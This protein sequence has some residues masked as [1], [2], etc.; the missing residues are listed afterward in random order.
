MVSNTA[1]GNSILGFIPELKAPGDVT[2]T[3]TSNVANLNGAHGMEIKINEGAVVG[4]NVNVFVE[5][6]VVKSNG[7]DGIRLFVDSGS[8]SYDIDFGG[9]TLGSL[10]NNSFTNNGNAAGEFDLHDVSPLIGA[11]TI[12]AQSNF[13]NDPDPLV[14]PEAGE[15]YQSDNGNTIDVSNHLTSDPNP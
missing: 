13:W 12:F 6:N 3:L 8:A 4:T 1:T 9:G 11:L 5:Q 2:L 14:D 7:N 10:G 15:E